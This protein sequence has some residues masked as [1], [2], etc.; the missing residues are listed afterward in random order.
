MKLISPFLTALILLLNCNQ[1]GNLPVVFYERAINYKIIEGHSETIFFDD[2][3]NGTISLLKNGIK[4]NNNNFKFKKDIK[5]LL[6]NKYSCGGDYHN[7]DNIG[8]TEILKYPFTIEIYNDTLKLL[9][10]NNNGIKYDKSNKIMQLFSNDSLIFS[11][12]KM[13]TMYRKDTN[14]IDKRTIM[15]ENCNIKIK[16]KGTLNLKTLKYIK[17]SI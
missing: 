2:F 10:V 8:F 4:I 11:C 5:A 12:S 9:N 6:I 7:Y 13:D 14:G 3:A 1:E 15:Q 16:Y 17:E